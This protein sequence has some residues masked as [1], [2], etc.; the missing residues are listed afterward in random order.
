[1]RTPHPAVVGTVETWH[2][3]EGWGVLRTPDGL[4]VFCHFSDVESKGTA[5]LSVGSLIWFDY[6]TPGQDGCEGRV[7]T[8][9]R[10]GEADHTVPLGELV[11]KTPEPPSSA[12][13]TRVVITYDDGRVETIEDDL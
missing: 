2:R 3:D 9:A 8:A 1:M 13:R 6:E 11:P 7:L 10:P 12:C 4:S 5:E